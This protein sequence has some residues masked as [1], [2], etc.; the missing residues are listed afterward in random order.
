[1]EKWNYLSIINLNNMADI[2]QRTIK[3]NWEMRTVLY[4]DWYLLKFVPKGPNYNKQITT[5]SPSLW[6]NNSEQDHPGPELSSQQDSFSKVT[7]HD[8]KTI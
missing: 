5:G 3:Y 8:T 2:L 6:M 1:M 4:F 7:A